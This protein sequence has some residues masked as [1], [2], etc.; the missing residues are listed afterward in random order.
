[1]NSDE[2]SRNVA[3]SL[4]AHEARVGDH[5]VDHVPAVSH[6]LHHATTELSR[7]VGPDGCRVLLVRALTR[8]KQHH[9]ALAN[10]EVVSHSAPVLDG[11]LESVEQN[12]EQ[13]VAAGLTTTLVQLFELL[14]R[15]IGDDLTVKL[16]EQITAGATP[17]AERDNE[18]LEP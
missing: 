1:M 9:P 8:T 4:I 5:T 11:V 2:I 13:A 6:A 14:R 17:G 18:E 12:G 15:V 7:W 10:V 3:S 16:A